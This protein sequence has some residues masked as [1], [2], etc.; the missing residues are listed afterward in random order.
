MSFWWPRVGLARSQPWGFMQTSG[1]GY[2]PITARMSREAENG[3]PLPG[4]T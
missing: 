2:C 1:Y 3:E 4:A